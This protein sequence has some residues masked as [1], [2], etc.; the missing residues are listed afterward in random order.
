M[1]VLVRDLS[2]YYP[3]TPNRP[4]LQGVSLRIAPQEIVG[5]TGASGCGK[6]TLLHILAGLHTH[7]RG[8]VLLDGQVPNPKVHTI[9]LVQQQYGLLPWMRVI[10]NIE[11]PS[12]IRHQ[13]FDHDLFDEVCY[14]M[15]LGDLL[16]R[17]PH[18]LSGGQKQRVALARAFCRKPD[19]LLLD[20]S[21]SA[22]DLVTA[23]R[24]RSLFLELWQR[25]PVSTLIISHNP[26]ELTRICRQT[27]I[28]GGSPA[29]VVA[30]CRDMTEA[31]LHR[32]LA[33][34]YAH[35]NRMP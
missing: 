22:L 10:R 29:S 21:F 7:Y 27:L 11:L 15:E 31:A 14:A 6:S 30:T 13:T 3:Q 35:E 34:V 2:A 17:Y 33:E 4:I 5:L 26:E 24:C 1:E 32:R 9:A 23:D 28:L 18:Q 20:E 25:R 8:D 19:L 12:K 16:N